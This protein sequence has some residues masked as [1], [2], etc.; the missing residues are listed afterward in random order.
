MEEAL[1]K[2]HHLWVIFEEE[3]IHSDGF[4]LPHQH[5]L[6]HYIHSIVLFGSQNGLCSLITES[7]H[8]TAVKKP[9]HCLNCNKPLLQILQTKMLL[10]KLSAAWVKFGCC[11]MLK[12]SVLDTALNTA[13]H[14]CFGIVTNSEEHLAEAVQE[15]AQ[16]DDNDDTNWDA[17][18]EPGRNNEDNVHEVDG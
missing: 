1:A 3:G 8:I 2:F 15:G 5:V 18:V 13:I 4:P 7:K 9:W 11:S 10:S 6:M 14:E 12:G 16:V 17:E